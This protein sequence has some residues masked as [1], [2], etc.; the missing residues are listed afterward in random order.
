[1]TELHR[2]V[3]MTGA[4]SLSVAAMTTKAQDKKISTM[5]H[6]A[7]G[8]VFIGATLLNNP[9]DDHAGAGRILQY[10]AD[11]KEKGVLWV[12]GTTHLVGGLSFAPDG[13]LWAFDNLAWK[14]VRVGSDG[15]Q[16]DARQLL[17]RAIGKVQFLKNGNYVL[18]EYFKGTAQPQGLTTRYKYLPDHPTEVGMGGLYEFSPDGKLV[19]THYPEVTGG[20]SGSMAITHADLA[21]DGK[22]LIYTSETGLRVM[23]YDLAARKQLSDLKTLAPSQGGPPAMVFD[24]AVSG[25]RVLLPLGN[26]LEVLSEDGAEIA[27]VPLPGFGWAVAAASMDAEAAYAGNWFT[28]DVVKVSLKDGAVTAKVNVGPKCISGLVQYKG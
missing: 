3:L 21:S 9:A 8:D 12:E 10:D 16:I 24:V 11:L 1:M 14:V 23:R 26:R 6:F 5:K 2:R 27:K 18:S 25:A 28:G 7:K 4:F 22:T 15:K 19:H 20:V 13:T 17:D